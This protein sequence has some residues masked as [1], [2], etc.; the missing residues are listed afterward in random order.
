MQPRCRT[1]LPSL[2]HCETTVLVFGIQCKTRGLSTVLG[3]VSTMTALR[4]AWYCGSEFR[5]TCISI[6]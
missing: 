6:I 2:K 1:D 5:S 3:S 4:G